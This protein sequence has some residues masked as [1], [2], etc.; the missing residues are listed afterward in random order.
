MLYI[1][2]VKLFYEENHLRDFDLFLLHAIYSA[3]IFIVEIP[4]GYLSDVWGRKK[5][6]LLGLL[7][8]VIGFITYS[9]SY[10]FLGFLLAEVA[11]GFGLG[12]V[13]G[14]DSAILYDSLLQENKQKQYIKYEGRI[15][16]SGNLAE[17]MAGIA[18]TILAFDT[19]RNYYRLQIVFMVFALIAACF[20]IE[21]NIH[22]AGLKIHWKSIVSIVK[23][24]L[25]KNRRLSKYVLFSAII[26]FAS[27]TMAWFAQIYL[28]EAG[29]RKADFG[30]L[31]T[32]LNLMVAFGSY[33]SHKIDRIFHKQHSLI[34]ILIFLSGGYFLSAHFISIYGIGFLL[35]FYFIRGM[36]H[37]ILKER[38]NTLTTSNVR[39]TVLSVRSML[40]RL[41]FAVLGPLLGWYTDK[42]SL[43]FALTLC[44]FIVLI[45]GIILVYSLHKK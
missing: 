13:S 44:G 8:G 14:T 45:P 17:A 31:W 30:V 11:L 24:T 36:A 41:M 18:V 25:W 19:M 42:I 5:T 40:I 26:G 21:P 2:V 1:P 7:F 39:A 10:G 3:I 28:F 16:A 35:I 34:F 12:F 22:K 33:S 37:P 4:S 43:S 9:F 20:L 38:I 6:M 32:L 27:L 23:D 29:V 15:T